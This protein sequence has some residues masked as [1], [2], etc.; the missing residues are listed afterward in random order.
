[1][2]SA[3]LPELEHLRV[4]DAMHAGLISC[5]PETPL[6]S[7]ARMLATY[8]VHAI[9]VPARRPGDAGRTGP[10]TI[11]SDVDIARAAYRG[12]IDELTADDA[13]T[14]PTA[15]IT[16]DEPLS[17]A[18]ETMLANELSHVIVVDAHNG[19]P[20]GVVSLLDIARTLAGYAGT[21]E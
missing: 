2:W 19:R 20:L 13:A 7:V 14:T 17:L 5:P 9:V 18:I 4:A 3:Q 10:W 8:R 21:G 1:V 12:A 6:R 15:S 16:R 11:V